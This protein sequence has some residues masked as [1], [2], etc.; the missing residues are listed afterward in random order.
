M[1]ILGVAPKTQERLVESYPHRTDLSIYEA[2]RLWRDE[3][4]GSK[5]VLK[6]ALRKALLD[7]GRRDIVEKLEEEQLNGS[8]EK[9]N[10][11]SMV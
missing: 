10:I 6:G 1:T 8:A 9:V 2:L 11:R 5:E 3:A 7:V 4:E